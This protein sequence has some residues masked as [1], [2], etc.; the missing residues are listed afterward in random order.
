MVGFALISIIEFTNHGYNFMSLPP[1]RRILDSLWLEFW[2]PLPLL[3][4]VFWLGGSLIK[5][6]VL[7]RPYTTVST[8]QADTERDVQLSLTVLLIK[9]KIKKSEGLTQVEVRTVDSTLKKLEFEFPVTEF[10]QVESS[11]A[12]KLGL[13]REDVRKLVRYQVKE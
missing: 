10:E 3:G 11:I 9:A 2:L 4:V 8:L 6:Q 7:S 1:W 5:D 12:Q 13:S